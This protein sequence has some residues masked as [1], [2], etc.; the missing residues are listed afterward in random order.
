MSENTRG[1][2]KFPKKA[3]KT[4]IDPAN[5]S[6]VIKKVIKNPPTNPY[7]KTK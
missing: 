5:T 1:I 6:G 2:E 7:H 3:I 4:L